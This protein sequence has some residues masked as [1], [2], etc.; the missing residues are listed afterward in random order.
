MKPFTDQYQHATFAGGC[1]WCL[2]GP[3]EAMD[4]V[5]RVQ[6]GYTGGLGENPSYEAVCTGKTGHYEAVDIQYDPARITFSELVDVFWKQIDPTDPDGQFADRGSQYQTAIFYHD[7]EQQRIAEESKAAL[8][9]S[10]RFVKPIVTKILPAQTFYP[11]ED[12]HQGY[13]RKNPGHYSLYRQGSGRSEYLKNTWGACPLR[14]AGT[15]SPNQKDDE[16]AAK[17]AGLTPLQYWV[18]QSSGTEPPFCNEYWDNHRE[19]IY[20]DVVSGVPLFSSQD[21]FDSGC[22]WPSFAKPLQA[23]SII[24]QEDRSHHMLR[25]EVRSRDT[26]SHLGH[27]FNDGPGPDGLRY[28]IN[29]AALKFIPVDMLV[30]E[31]YGEYLELF[32]K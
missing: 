3:F 12:Y 8:Q 6:S 31:G 9:T 19:G 29:S 2:V 25:T 4:G 10:G 26:D 1:F 18:T 14:P 13:Y 7:V 24:A 15:R 32:G 23:E 11:A 28:C 20:V 22:G 16:L 30:K 17:K 27:V 21:K 5:I